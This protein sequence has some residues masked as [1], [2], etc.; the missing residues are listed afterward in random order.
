MRIDQGGEFWDIVFDVVSLVSS[1]I[2]VCKTPTDP[3]AWA[4][5]AGD[6]VDLVPFVTG[7]GETVKVVSA[8]NKVVDAVD[9]AH[10]VAKASDNIVDG[11]KIAK[12]T[13]L[14]EEAKEISKTLDRSSGYTK[15]TRSA[16][17]KI[18]N[19]YKSGSP[20]NPEW[21]EYREI[22]RIRPD[23]VDFDSNTIFELKPNNLRSIRQGINQLHKYDEALGGGFTLVLE[24]Y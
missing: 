8:A 6:V 22:P 11:V 1:V 9:T 17:Q 18:H 24:L 3:M 4:S 10:D 23:Y 14:T 7:V 12:A 19:G 15:S 13:D 2:D 16:G 21:K 20:F 5:L